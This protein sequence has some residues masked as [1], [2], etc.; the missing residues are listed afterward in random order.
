MPISPDADCRMCSD[1]PVP[2]ARPHSRA[3]GITPHEHGLWCSDNCPTCHGR[4][5]SA[6]VCM[7]CADGTHTPADHQGVAPVLGR[8]VAHPIDRIETMS[9]D[10]APQR[11]RAHCGEV[12]ALCPVTSQPDQYSLMIEYD[13]VAGHVI[14]SKSLKL[15]LWGYRDR[16]ISCEELAARVLLDLSSQ[17][18]EHAGEGS[19]MRVTAIQQSRGGIV[20][21]AVAETAGS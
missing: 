7:L 13:T 6:G 12:S 19:W 18:A 16:G 17:Y 2:D 3:C 20:L 11:V 8:V 4:A 14:E 10:V 5:E 15:Y 1:H 9:L 21:E